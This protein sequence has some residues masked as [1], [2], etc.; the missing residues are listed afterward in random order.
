MP[1]VTPGLQADAWLDREPDGRRREA[2]D[3]WFLAL[4]AGD[5]PPALRP[6]R[7]SDVPVAVEIPDTDLV[8]VCLVMP[9]LDA[10]VIERIEF[11]EAG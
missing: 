1:R 5:L 7:A 4:A 9:L 2:V 10:I 11:V 6:W 8:A 3:R